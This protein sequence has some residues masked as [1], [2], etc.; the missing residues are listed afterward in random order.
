MAN[1]VFARHGRVRLQSALLA[2]L[3]APLLALT[4]PSGALVAH[5]H[6]ARAVAATII[7][8]IV[9]GSWELVFLFPWIIPVEVTVQSLVAAFGAAYAIGW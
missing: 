4:S 3:A 6:I 7:T 5:F 2:V 1:G 8:L 9:T